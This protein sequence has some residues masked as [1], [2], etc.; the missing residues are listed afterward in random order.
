[1]TNTTDGLSP[2]DRLMAEAIPTRPRPAPKPEPPPKPI[3]PWTRAEQ[4]AHWA[5]LCEA[6]G[7]RHARR[8]HLRLITTEEPEPEAEAS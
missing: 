8:P 3:Q 2:Y 7:T 4:D 1:M 5:A 6:V